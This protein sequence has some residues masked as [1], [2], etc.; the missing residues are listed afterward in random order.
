MC[1][2][3]SRGDGAKVCAISVEGSLHLLYI[4]SFCPILGSSID[5]ESSR[6]LFVIPSLYSSSALSGTLSNHSALSLAHV[7]VSVCTEL[8]IRAHSSERWLPFGSHP[9]RS[10]FSCFHFSQQ[11]RPI[12]PSSTTISFRT[13]VRADVFAQGMYSL[14]VYFYSKI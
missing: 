12:G 11:N 13:I 10:F 2:P 9:K 7:L 14:L 4:C 8:T 3:R 6:T 1:V 5:V